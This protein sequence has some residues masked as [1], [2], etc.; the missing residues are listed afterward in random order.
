MV[1]ETIDGSV[2]WLL[3]DTLRTPIEQYVSAYVGRTWRVTHIEDRADQASHPAAILSDETY[4]VF[5]K[6]GEGDLACDQFKREVAGLHLL[7]QRAGVLTPTII[8]NIE[9]DGGAILMMEA[10]RVIQREQTQWQQI[11]QALAQ[12]HSTKWDRYGLETHCYW[13]DL[14]Q[15]NAPLADWATFFGERR[16]VPR[17]KAAV[18][19]GHLPLDLVPEIENL[20]ARLPQLCG[21]PVAPS[22]LH[23]DAQQN[24]FLSTVEGPVIIDP[25]AYYG[26]PEMDLAYVD[27][28]FP[29][30]DELYRGYEQVTPLDPGFIERRDLWRIP[31]WLAMVQ[32]C[33]PQYVGKLVAAL[34]RY[35]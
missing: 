10:V 8:A 6:L 17:L 13:G 32:V 7:T 2:A 16:L 28:F 29:V 14:Y 30:S 25:A 21:P 19:S 33:G 5:V 12:L 11:G 1:Q 27:F 18:E 24:N 31:A 4:A 34:R 23:G 15:D 3:S 9:V 26:H 22:L 35:I 20:R